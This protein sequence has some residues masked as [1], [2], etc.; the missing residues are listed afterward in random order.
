MPVSRGVRR[1]VATRPTRRARDAGTCFGQGQQPCGR[2]LCTAALAPPV[3]PASSRSRA[4][5]ASSA[6][7]RS[8][9]V[10]QRGV[11]GLVERHQGA[12][13]VVLVVGDAQAAR[14]PHLCDRR[15]QRGPLRL[16]LLAPLVV[17]HGRPVGHW[18]PTRRAVPVDGHEPWP[19]ARAD[20]GAERHQ[21]PCESRE[22]RVHRDQ[23]VGLEPGH[24]EVLRGVGRVEVE[25]RAI[26]HAVRRDTR[27]PS[28]RIFS[29]VTRSC[30]SSA[31]ASVSSPART[32][33][34]SN[35]STWDRIRFGATAGGPG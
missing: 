14:G 33:A 8:V 10:Q 29:S 7:I 2:D 22:R 35:A 20:T 12:V 5:V 26:R 16:H 25:P 17:E 30:W 23:G 32:A 4:A 31:T 21:V 11:A 6:R 27:S 34:S 15:H 1:R 24:G 13:R 28:S 3:R 18:H 19:S 9:P